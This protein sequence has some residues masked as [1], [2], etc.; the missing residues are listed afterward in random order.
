MSAS[1]DVMD[2][3]MALISSISL[4]ALLFASCFLLDLPTAGEAVL[5]L[6]G[7]FL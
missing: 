6:S 5:V 3:P 1:S 7:P 2:L 4:A